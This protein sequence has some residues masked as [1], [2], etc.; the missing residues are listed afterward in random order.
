MPVQQTTPAPQPSQ[1][2]VDAWFDLN[3]AQCFISLLHLDAAVSKIQ[4]T[5]PDLPIVFGIHPF[6]G[7]GTSQ[8]NDEVALTERE[9]SAFRELGV[10][11]S[12]RILP[13][14]LLPWHLVFLARDY[15][16][17]NSR[18][19][20]LLAI[21]ALFR[22]QYEVGANLS[23][24][25]TLLSVAADLELPGKAALQCLE[26]PAVAEQL[27][28]EFSTALHLGI[29]TVPTV[30]LDEQVVMAAGT[31]PKHYERALLEVLKTYH[32]KETNND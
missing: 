9:R 3:V 8:T 25:E 12:S 10:P 27:H 4:E 16:D 13:A 5:H 19:R 29:T 26:D 7:E 22:A 6:L 24:P 14:G 17:R 2:T 31:D 18:S 21:N 30:L 23:N 32:S 28:Y 1:L 15:D 20:Q 11:L